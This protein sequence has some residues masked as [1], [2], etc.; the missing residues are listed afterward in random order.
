MKNKMLIVFAASLLIAFLPGIALADVTCAFVPTVVTQ[1][2]YG[3]RE[4]NIFVCGHG[5]DWNCYNLGLG[6]DPLA[7]NRLAVATAAVVS[8]QEIRLLFYAESSCE[9]ARANQTVPNATWLRRP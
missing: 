1:G 6:N 2:A 9:N 5:S 4:A 3:G 8:S 7:K